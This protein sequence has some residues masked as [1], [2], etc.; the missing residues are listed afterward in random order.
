MSS[1]TR[2]A[3]GAVYGGRGPFPV[4]S[5]SQF[6]ALYRRYGLDPRSSHPWLFDQESL[7]HFRQAGVLALFRALG[8]RREHR[9]LSLG[10]G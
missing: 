3:I 4:Y 8:I 9:V 7:S 6:K 2:A 10:E 5:A 1:G